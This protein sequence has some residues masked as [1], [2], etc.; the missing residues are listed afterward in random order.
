MITL[1]RVISRC[2]SPTLFS[3]LRCLSGPRYL[4]PN[5]D[6]SKIAI[7]DTT[8]SHSFERLSSLTSTVSDCVRSQCIRGSRVALVLPSCV[9]FPAAIM[10]VM[11][12]NC[13]PVPLNPKVGTDRIRKYCSLIG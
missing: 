6:Q 7:K 11:H 12:A 3:S 10:G 2:R 9:Q 4:I 1:S 8:G 5:I 13:V